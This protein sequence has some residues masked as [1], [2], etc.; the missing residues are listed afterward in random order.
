MA[1][2][3]VGTPTILFED[4]HVLVAVKPAGVLSQADASGAPD[5]LTLLKAYLCKKYNKPGEAYLGLLHRLDRP[6]R[7]VMVFAK[8]SK[9]AAR[10]SAQIR[11]RQVTKYYRAIVYGTPN[12]SK[13][14]IVSYLVKN[15]KENTVTV[16][17]SKEKAPKGA[18]LASLHYELIGEGEVLG[19]K[20]SLLSVDLHS[21]RSHQIR[22]QLADVG[23]PI[24][25]DRKYGPRPNHYAGDICLESYHIGFSH[26]ISGAPMTFDLSISDE[27]PWAQFSKE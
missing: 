9:C 16:Y 15:E 23:M 1:D 3:Y 22:A 17:P 2:S 14:E 5:M 26:P 27:A 12:E 13:G 21:G 8:T 20:V 4:N 24:V 6:V 7:G 11:E 10:I 18:K 19:K 25:G